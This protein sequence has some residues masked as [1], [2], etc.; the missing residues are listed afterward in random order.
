MPPL[1]FGLILL[2]SPFR[3]CHEVFGTVPDLFSLFPWEFFQHFPSWPTVLPLLGPPIACFHSS[4]QPV[5]TVNAEGLSHS[6]ADAVMRLAVFPFGGPEV[7]D[8]IIHLLAPGTSN[9]YL[10]GANVFLVFFRMT[11]SFSQ[12]GR[13]E[14]PP[15][16]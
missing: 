8:C 14:N 12:P 15:A 4:D 13:L 16:N 11:R 10:R 1:G 7:L 9:R 2:R 6:V 5:W 3:R